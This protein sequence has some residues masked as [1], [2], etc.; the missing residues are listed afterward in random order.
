[1]EQRL[2]RLLLR[3]AQSIGRKT[4]HAIV[5]DVPRS[6]QD[7]AELVISTPYTVSRI[8]ADWRRLGVADAQCER[9]L[10]LDQERL[11]AIAH[12]SDN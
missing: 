6:G 8:L 10:L 2:S 11:A 7:L 5:L 9:I 4:V 3:L 1:M 12:M